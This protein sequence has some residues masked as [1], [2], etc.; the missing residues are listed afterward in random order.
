VADAILRDSVQDGTPFRETPAGKKIGFAN[1][2]NAT[3]LF[4]ICPTALLLGLWDSTGPKG[5]QGAKFPRCL[6]SEVIGIDVE[7][8]KKTSSRIDPLQIPVAAGT[9]YEARGGGGC[10]SDL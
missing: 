8:G 4:E 6:V 1:L 2:R 3:P 9:L 5:G 7:R 10:T